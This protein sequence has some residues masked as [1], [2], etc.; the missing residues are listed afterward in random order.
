MAYRNFMLGATLAVALVVPTLAGGLFAT[1]PRDN[2]L[3]ALATA[4][5]EVE[6]QVLS[7]VQAWS[8]GLADWLTRQAAKL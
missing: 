8:A 7:S 4:R 1:S 5:S 6:A 2:S 3:T